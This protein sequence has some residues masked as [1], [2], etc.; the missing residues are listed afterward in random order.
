MESDNPCF[1]T[2]TGDKPGISNPGLGPLALNPPGTTETHALLDGSPA[3]DAVLTGCPPPGTDQRG[4]TRP[5]GSACDMGAYEKIVSVLGGAIPTLSDATRLGL[6]GLML[7]GG[8]WALR[9]RSR[10]GDL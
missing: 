3:I 8:L 4:I 6:A 2:A 9:R 10:Q 1:L 5:Q 7:L